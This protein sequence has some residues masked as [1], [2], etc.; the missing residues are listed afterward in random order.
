[1]VSLEDF[2]DYVAAV[3]YDERNYEIDLQ[4]YLTHR[5]NLSC[6]GC[7]MRASPSV[8]GNVLPKSDVAFYLNE[9]QKEPQFTHNVVFSGGEIFTTELPYLEYNISQVL[10]RGNALQLKTNGAWIQNTH[11]RDAILEMLRRLKPGR[12]LVATEEQINNF[13]VSK[14]RWLLRMLGRDVVRQWMYRAL[15]TTSLLS[16]VV[17]VD[18]KL[19]PKESAQWFL[20]IVK[21]FADDKRLV[22]N[23]D[24]KTFTVS[25]AKDFF[26][27]NILN[28]LACECVDRKPGVNLL[29]YT[30]NGV[31][32]ESYFGDFVDVNRISPREKLKNFV[33]PAL[34]NARGRLVYCFYPDRTVGLDSCYLQSVGRVSYIGTDGKY[35]SFN[36]IRRDI[37]VQLALDYR[38]EISK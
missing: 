11:A 36:K 7:Y 14:P 28:T 20:D 1:M 2:A 19:H 6:N 22:K 13:L 5:C 37:L 24:L 30:L 4:F 21:N 35:K 8:F 26:Y 9:F 12:G 38:R 32:I 31:P 15:P 17:S 34:G 10:N 18:N 16:M 23:I 25:C 3:I 27:G 33:L 29:K